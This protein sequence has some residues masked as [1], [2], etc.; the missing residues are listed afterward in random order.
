MNDLVK[1][2]SLLLF[3]AW[4]APS[5]ALAKVTPARPRS[6]PARTSIPSKT[7]TLNKKTSEK[8]G[9]PQAP[10]MPAPAPERSVFT[11]EATR[12]IGAISLGLP[13]VGYLING[14]GLKSDPR[15]VVTVPQH[16]FGTE[17]TIAGL[18]RAIAAVQELF[19]NSPP[20]MIGSLSPQGGGFAPPHKSHRTGR[21]VDVYFYKTDGKTWFKPAQH[22]DIDYPR[23]WAILKAF[24]TQTPIDYVLLDRQLQTWFREYATSIGEDPLWLKQM[25]E[26]EGRYPNPAIKHEPGHNNHF[27]VRF[28]SPIARERGRLLYDQLVAEGH[29]QRTERKAK[30]VVRREDSLTRVAKAYHTSTERIVGLNQLKARRL[31]VGQILIVP[32]AIELP[33]AKAPVLLA[34]FPKPGEKASGVADTL[35]S[36]TALEQEIDEALS[37]LPAPAP[38]T[39]Q[40]Q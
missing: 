17:E 10:R 3:L 33:G 20:V 23:S 19:P 6:L 27:H 7:L 32:E 39:V 21:D 2:A 12:S 22:D 34:N 1:R 30:H 9:L 8:S 11:T 4:L 37:K 28:A 36:L 24:L 40:E 16:R 5:P 31:R 25:F 13:H 35:S 14:V 18:T 29:L 38:V 15:W 26:G